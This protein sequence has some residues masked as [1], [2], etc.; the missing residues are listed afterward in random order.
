[1]LS[2]E[3]YW[4]SSIYQLLSSLAPSLRAIRPLFV[5]NVS[6]E[7]ALVLLVA[8]SR[9][10]QHQTHTRLASSTSQLALDSLAALL[11]SGYAVTSLVRHRRHGCLESKVNAD[12]IHGT[13]AH[14]DM[15][16]GSHG[17]DVLRASLP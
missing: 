13:F 14:H 7:D 5:T 17:F 6:S 16:A 4:R 11:D 8:P 12:L 3:S 2:V 15:N 9:A 10:M 1:M